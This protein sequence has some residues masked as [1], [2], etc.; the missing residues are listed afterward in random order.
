MSNRHL[1]RSIV[2]QTLFEWDFPSTGSEQA[3]AEEIYSIFEKNIREFAPGTNDRPFMDHLLKQVLEKKRDLDVLIEKRLQTG[4]LIRFLL[5][6]VI[7]C[8]WA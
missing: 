8:A 6:T 4:R 7:F 1:S 3:K 5:L 2:L